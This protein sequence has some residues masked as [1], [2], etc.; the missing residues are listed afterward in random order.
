M[1][2]IILAL[3]LSTCLQACGGD[4]S[5]EIRFGSW[6]ACEFERVRWAHAGRE[7]RG[8]MMASF[9]RKHPAEGMSTAELKQ[10]LGE[11][12]AYADYDQDPAYLVGPGSAGR[13][14]L[15]VFRTHRLTGRIVEVQVLPEH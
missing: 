12:T 7:G 4:T 5:I 10:L 6:G 14:Q 2:S 8:C 1:R 3:C 15:L 13:G 11:P 9:L